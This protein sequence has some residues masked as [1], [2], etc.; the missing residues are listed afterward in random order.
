MIKDLTIKPMVSPIGVQPLGQ[1][2]KAV[3]EG[4][5]NKFLAPNTLQGA[6][7][8]Q[9][10][11]GPP[12]IQVQQ[13]GQPKTAAVAN[14]KVM[15]H[16]PLQGRLSKGASKMTKRQMQLKVAGLIKI[17]KCKAK[18]QKLKKKAG[19]EVAERT[20]GDMISGGASSVGRGV[21]SPL[22]KLLK[23]LG[24][25]ETGNKMLADKVLSGPMK[26]PVPELAD[27]YAEASKSMRNLGYGTVGAGA[28]AAGLG[29][30]LPFV[31]RKKRKEEGEEAKE[32]CFRGLQEGIQLTPEELQKFAATIPQGA[33]AQKVYMEKVA[34]FWWPV[35]AALAAGNLLPPALHGINTLATKLFDP[36]T[37]IPH[38]PVDFSRWGG[39][40]PSDETD[41]RKGV[42]QRAAVESQTNG[43]LGAYSRAT[44][45]D[46]YM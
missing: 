4:A 26:N 41:F 9:V 37:Y 27:R 40:N 21:A 43:L 13:A 34:G 29:I 11:G 24:A 30:G 6:A 22:G 23:F 10:A 17:A 25:S 8:L 3:A 38:K 16:N 42:M 35:L 28:T 45:P 1:R 5:Q 20:L 46:Y 15:P 44:R 14:S 31:G 19:A 7:N 18:M 2:A 33:D 12:E 32:A 39:M 36:Y